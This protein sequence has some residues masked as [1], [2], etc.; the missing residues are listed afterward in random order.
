MSFT[1]ATLRNR[2]AIWALA[3][4]AA[5]FGT[6]AYVR[7]PVQLFPDTAPP[8]V[9]VI[10][11]WPGASA[12]DVAGDLSQDLEDEFASLEGIQ[13]VKSMS[14]DNLSVVTLEFDYARRVEMAAVDVQNAISRMRGD[15]PAGIREPQVLQFSTNDRPIVTV[16][17]SASSPTVARRMAE[18]TVAA[19]LQRVP[20]VAAVDVFG[21]AQE[22][23]LVELDPARLE[24]RGVSLQQ[25]VQ[26]IRAFNV[27]MPAGEL[28][29]EHTQSSL[30][31][32]A[33]AESPE[34]LGRIPIPI[35]GGRR[36]L[37]SDL[38]AVR[39]GALD[40]DAVFGIN[41]VQ[42][43]AVQVFKTTDAN[44]VDV[45]ERVTAA[46]GSIDADYPELTLQVG[47]ESG[48]FAKTSVS[49]LLGNV[50]QALLMASLIIFLFIGRVK[51]SLVVV[52][53]MPLSYGITFGLMYLFGVEFN[54]VT[55]TAVILAVGMVVDASVVVLENIMR[56]RA[57]HGGTLAEAAVGGTDEVRLPVLAG[58]ATTVIVLIPL[59]FLEGFVGK[60]FGPLALTLLFAFTSSVLVALILLPTLALWA[61]DAGWLDRITELLA[62]PFTWLMALV[63]R[64]Y[65][66]VLRGAL[67][68][69]L[70]TVGAAVAA[71]A[72]GV[73]LMRS[74]GMEML[75]HMDS[76]A[77]FVA[78][79]T[80]PGT[81]LGETRRVV[82][83]IEELVRAYPEV[84]LVQWQAGFEA[85]MRSLSGTG[86]QGPTQGFLS[87]TL[88]DRTERETTIWEIEEELRDTVARVPG[89]QSFTI[90]EQGST[91]KAT[92]SAPILVRLSGPDA[93]VLDRLGEEVLRRLAGVRHLRQPVR[94]WRIDQPRETV[95]VNTLQA[96]Q[97]GL[98]PASVAAELQMGST[99]IAAGDLYAS[100]GATLPIRLRYERQD[101][102]EPSALLRFPVRLPSGD[103]VALSSVASVEPTVGQG[104]VTRENAAA[105][106]EVSAFTGGGTLSFIINEVDAA[107]AGL[108]VPSGYD[109]ELTGEKSDLA[110]SKAQLIGAL[111]A[112]ILAVYL[113]LVAQLRSFVHPV[114][115]LMSV[116]L[117]ISG[118]GFA[119]WATGKPVSMPVMIGL[120]LL[121]GTVVNNA[122]IL[123]DFIQ[124]QRA[125]GVER[126]EAILGSVRTRFRPV[127]MTSMSTVIGMIPL[128]AEWALGAERF[129]PLAVA[130]IGGMSAATL[131]TLIVIPTL[132]DLF[133]SASVR[134]GRLLRPAAA[135]SVALVFALA[136]PGSV[137]AA[138]ASDTV[139]LSVEQAVERATAESRELRQLG[140]QRSAADE[141]V[142]Q[143]LARRLPS[144]DLQARYTRL[145]HVE[146]GALTMPFALPGQEPQTM[147]FGEPIDNSWSGRVAVSQPLFTGFALSA[148]SRA[149]RTGVDLAAAGL[150]RGALDLRLQ[151][152]Q[153]YWSTVR[154]REKVQLARQ[155]LAAV[156]QRVALA[157]TL[158][159]AGRA[160]LLD[161]RQV[162]AKRAETA[163]GLATLEGRLQAAQAALTDLVG[164]PADAAL[165]LTEPMDPPG[166]SELERARAVDSG[167]P[168]TEER[169]AALT[170]EARS[171]QAVAASG[172][173]W[174]K[175]SLQA[176]YTLAN[177]HERYFPPRDE[178]NDS[179]DVSVVLQWTAWDW[180][181]TRSYAREQELQAQRAKTQLEDVRRKVSL[182]ERL[183]R[184]ELGSARARQEAAGATALALEVAREAT[185]RA[186]A[187]GRATPL[188]EVQADLDL[189]GARGALV[190]AQIDV[191]LALARLARVSAG[192]RNGGG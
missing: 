68:Q 82:G 27:A 31:V 142:H 180:N 28:R 36:V 81:S 1:K 44:T 151:V 143:A 79:Q 120:I 177:P 117:S 182:A 62:R 33:R 103:M 123:L 83:R 45:V 157:Q 158:H 110:E 129:S 8:I 127:M 131:L 40:D 12:E 149:A 128:A 167:Q 67:K 93:L 154:V 22:A 96:A 126:R 97:V 5:V 73:V 153:A 102:H 77:F 183:A 37:L 99:G 47:E 168:V 7:M 155:A 86:A 9:N 100:D 54:M 49:N 170:Y 138:E 43:I 16:G 163:S 181:R 130:V 124:E 101:S 10:T 23:V 38:G 57:E 85:G 29:L 185:E 174:P 21:G 156:D 58:V 25:V 148:G 2:H 135:A 17:V 169:L 89:I 178:F 72:L 65:V 116:P 192:G 71:L 113:L 24:E 19:R 3:I 144:V 109:V 55:L 134:L 42:S 13:R 87:V 114:T 53:S 60:T 139:A 176:G 146:P 166:V 147:S 107:L 74:Q 78:V 84:R 14:Q 90:R 171:H 105:T 92:T 18:D 34:A 80:P 95:R 64:G 15:L 20:G 6:L 98:S 52:V 184:I 111:L 108:V 141:R 160:T 145:S 137:A 187:L 119:L 32:A 118:V 39:R 56:W 61:G 164:L 104:L 63:Q 69:R 175:L 132:Y 76:G 112:S 162:Q 173:L 4:A 186:R 140:L 75:P 165:Q 190:D 66:V 179:W 172:A 59:L 121:V 161:V 48:S 26:S 152:E 51:A 41:G 94:N 30:R 88:T 115:I 150:Q 70:L 188:E 11:V 133:D 35:A 159:E 189:S 50:L 122:I 125:R 46:V 191:R 91:A 106:L 136:W